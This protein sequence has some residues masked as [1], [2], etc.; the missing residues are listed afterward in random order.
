MGDIS[1]LKYP[2]KSHRKKASLPRP[3][4]KLAE[5]VGIMIGDGG[6]G[7]AW[8]AVITV[9]AIV[10]KDYAKYIKNLCIDLF[11][12][13]PIVRKRMNRQALDIVLTSINVVDF[14]VSCGL[15]RGNKLAQGLEIPGWIMQNKSFRKACLRGL[16]DTDG[17]IF[18]HEHNVN[19]KEYRNIGLCFTSYSP[20]LL[21]Q[22]ACVFEEFEV[23]PHIDTRWKNVYLYRADAV[24]KYLKIFGTSN[25]RIS[26]VYK[27]WRGGRVV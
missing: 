13:T 7:N 12:V 1:S 22:V 26:A 25:N 3:S 18:I 2:K 24:A 4:A 6:I 23:I 16:V 9:N 5:F 8:Q 19:K 14:L 17:C 11:D 27:K 15:P 20:E 21:R 10:D